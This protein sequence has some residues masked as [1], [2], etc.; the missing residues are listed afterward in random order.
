MLR[1]DDTP[2]GT[3]DEHPADDDAPRTA[4]DAAE[5]AAEA[6]AERDPRGHFL[7]GNKHAWKPGEPSPNPNGRPKGLSRLLREIGEASFPQDR[8]GVPID[9]RVLQALAAKAARGNVNA[10]HEWLDRRWGR[11]PISFRGPGGE[12]D[13]GDAAVDIEVRVVTRDDVD[14]SHRSMAETPA[15]PEAAPEAPPDDAA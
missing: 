6:I 13:L 9:V 1:M 3:P 15:A 11:V 12:D 4:A 8:E 2:L 14:T 7:P 10:I 5:R